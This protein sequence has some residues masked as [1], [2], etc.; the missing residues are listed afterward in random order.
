MITVAVVPSGAVGKQVFA[1]AS[2]QVVL[3]GLMVTPVSAN[4]LTT[5]RSGATSGDVIY[6]HS[7]LSAESTQHIKLPGCGIRFDKGMHVKVIGTGG[8]VYLEVE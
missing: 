1:I 5:I 3:K 4:V 7:A 2:N 6:T 8:K